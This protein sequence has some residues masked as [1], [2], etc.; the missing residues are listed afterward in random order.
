MFDGLWRRALDLKKAAKAVGEKK[1]RS[2]RAGCCRLTGYARGG[3][4]P[5]GM[6]KVPRRFSQLGGKPADGHRIRGGRSVIRWRPGS[7]DLMGLVRAET[8]DIIVETDYKSYYFEQWPC[9]IKFFCQ[10][11]RRT[12]SRTLM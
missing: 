8:A 12:T 10:G 3:C 5:V 1:I 9:W 2:T 7:A 11:A 6:K 4:S